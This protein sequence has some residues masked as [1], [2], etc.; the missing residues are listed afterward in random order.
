MLKII[1]NKIK[2]VYINRSY[3]AKRKYLIK[4]GARIGQGTRLNCTTNAFGSEPYLIEVG[5]NCLFA[6]ETCF[7]THDGGISVLN[8]LHKFLKA[9]KPVRMDKIAPIRI[10]NNV[11]TG[12]GAMIMPGVRIGNNVIIG[13]HSVVTHDIADNSVAVGIPA[14]VISSIEDYY[15]RSLP[16]VDETKKL[17]YPKKKAYYLKKFKL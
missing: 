15:R 17:S 9:G 4:Q 13:A 12:M 3:E 2:H 1:F 8:N 7:I 10:G 14:R 5:E 11:Y 6:A 16:K